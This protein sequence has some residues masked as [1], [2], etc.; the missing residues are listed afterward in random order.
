MNN[1]RREIRQR[2][3]LKAVGKNVFTLL[4][5]TICAAL[6]LVVSLTAVAGADKTAAPEPNKTAGVNYPAGTFPQW[7]SAADFNN[8]SKLDLITANYD[9][10]NVSILIGIGDGTFQFVGNGGVSCFGPLSIAT[11]DFNGDNKLDYAT[12]DGR[13]GS[14]SVAIGNGNGSFQG[15]N[16]YGAGICPQ[17]VITGDF[18][19]DNK[20]D[21]VVVNGAGCP[22]RPAK[23]DSKQAPEISAN[24]IS[25]S[26]G[27]GNGAFQN[28]I[29]YPAGSDP[30]EAVAA[31]YNRDGKLDLAVTNAS[32]SSVSILIGNGN[33]TFQIAITYPAGFQPFS[34]TKG[35]FNNDSKIDLAVTNASSASASVMFGNGD[36]TFQAPTSYPTDPRPT[37]IRAANVNGDSILDL[38]T[39][40]KEGNS[41]SVLLGNGD[42]SFQ[43]PINFPVGASPSSIASGDFDRDG[44]PDLAVANSLSNNVSVLLNCPGLT[45][46]NPRSKLFTMTGGEEGVKVSPMSLCS[47]AAVSDVNWIEVTSI[48]SGDGSDVVTYLLRENF[49]GSARQG[50]LTV[51]QQTVTIVQDG[52]VPAVDCGFSISPPGR[53]AH[54]N[55]GNGTIT[56][57]GASGCGWQATSDASWIFVTS[58]PVGIGNGAVTFSIAANST[59]VG[60]NGT[61]TIAG[62]KFNIKQKGS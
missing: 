57:T 59:G 48:G 24:S 21:L 62:K 13:C 53:T 56:L 14:G 9:S 45:A 35:D 38:V 55:G 5:F 49:T 51:G 15:P 17:S 27:N 29:S 23:G 20:L 2:L 22:V 16:P 12:A 1:S 18:N 42:G 19:A 32:N 36:G 43:P 8:D 31:D 7:I 3:A 44:T 39:A 47:W 10:D 41:V 52:G 40:N 46:I 4:L 6:S 61:I 37:S 28:M 11:G 58:T 33:G 50:S 30:R 34:I 25:I 54:V 60:R 26:M